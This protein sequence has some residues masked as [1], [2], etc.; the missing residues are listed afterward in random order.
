M[1]Q[2]V[3]TVLLAMAPPAGENSR[4]AILQRAKLLRERYQKQHQQSY[5]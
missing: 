1:L 4:A 2:L 5:G 3:A